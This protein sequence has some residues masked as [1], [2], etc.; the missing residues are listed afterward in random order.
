VSKAWD[1]GP[2]DDSDLSGQSVVGLI[3][4]NLVPVVGVLFLGWTM[5]V[6]LFLF[7]I[8][9][10]IVGFIGVLKLLCIS[11][12]NLREYRL[13]V[14]KQL[15]SKLFLVGFSVVSIGF[16]TYLQ[17]LA[18]LTMFAGESGQFTSIFTSERYPYLKWA[19]VRQIIQDHDLL[20]AVLFLIVGYVISFGINYIGKGGYRRAN[21]TVIFESFGRILVLFVT[22]VVGKALLAFQVSQVWGLL[23]LVGL[24][25]TL[26]VG[27]YLKRRKTFAEAT[28]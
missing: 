2:D 24:K 10:V 23:V 16:F 3:L 15:L 4:A 14:W 5:V 18:L 1:I 11:N 17:G 20:W 12:P 21:G 6:L 7:W 19:D 26:D 25:I 8:E 27:S 13:P 9:T 28:A 22:I